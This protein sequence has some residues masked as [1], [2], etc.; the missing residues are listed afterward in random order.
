VT[1][2]TP[3][4]LWALPAVFIPLLIHLWG[5]RQQKTQ[6]FSSL[7]LLEEI[8]RDRFHWRRW[9]NFILLVLRTLLVLLVVLFLAQPVWVPWKTLSGEMVVVVDASGSLQS[10]LSFDRNKNLVD[11]LLKNR[12]KNSWGLVV[13]SDR[14]EEV[15]SLTKDSLHASL[16]PT[17]RGTDLPLG[18]ERADALFSK[19]GGLTVVVSDGARHGWSRSPRLTKTKTVI[20]VEGPPAPPNAFVRGVSL[21]SSTEMTA[22]FGKSGTLPTGGW[23]LWVDGRLDSR[24]VLHWTKNESEAVVPFPSDGKEL[25]LRLTSDALRADNSWFVVPAPS[26]DYSILVVNGAPGLSPSGDETWCVAPVLDALARDGVTVET[27]SP[28]D[29]LTRDL[30]KT[31]VVAFFNPGPMTSVLKNKISSFVQGGGGLWVTSGDRG[32]VPSLGDLLSVRVGDVK[33]S[34]ESVQ[35]PSLWPD[36]AKFSWGTSRVFRYT[37]V[38]PLSSTLV[39]LKTQQS[40]DPLLVLGTRGQGRTALWCST[41]DQDWTDLPAHALYPV[42]VRR[43]LTHLSGGDP[44]GKPVF[45]GDS[46]VRRTTPGDVR[47]P[48]GRVE[49]TTAPNGTMTYG[50]VEQPGFY[51]FRPRGGNPFRVAVNLNSKNNEGD[52]TQITPNDLRSLLD[53]AVE[54]KWVSSSQADGLSLAKKIQGRSLAKIL[55]V[56]IIIV[57]LLETFLSL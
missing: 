22:T 15:V 18:L 23:S 14:V 49:P 42:F 46:I 55:V 32:G 44:F 37:N 5:K 17:H 45:V 1:F 56:L 40:R 48:D 11:D 38:T 3:G 29:L 20:F 43:V 2:L 35:P 57:F 53:P 4:A 8:V 47:L 25:E 39:V 33:G 26:L 30:S 10:G 51:L 36:L 52:L 12:V 16:R 19:P 54:M 28:S 34:E 6:S 9:L 50:P 13:V 21:T 41:V 27:V 7:S 24:G 31:N